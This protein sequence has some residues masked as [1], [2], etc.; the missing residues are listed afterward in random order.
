MH[1]E[2][3]RTM[4]SSPQTAI[5]FLER[6]PLPFIVIV[7]GGSEAAQVAESAFEI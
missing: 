5:L 3:P 4:E 1:K 2:T 7:V 6:L